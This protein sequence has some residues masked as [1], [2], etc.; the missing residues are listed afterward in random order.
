MS[1]R[2]MKYTCRVISGYGCLKAL[3]QVAVNFKAVV[4]RVRHCHVAIR[5]KGQALR[6]VK[7]ISWSVD[8]GQERPWAVKHLQHRKTRQVSIFSTVL[9][10]LQVFGVNVF[11]LKVN[12]D[13][14]VSPI[15]N[16]NISIGIDSHACW[17]VELAVSL[18]M[19]AKF[20]EELPISIV[21]L[22]A[23]LNTHTQKK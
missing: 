3:L 4:P 7:W 1:L 18:T 21:Y 16:N 11:F 13:P 22:S 12:L 19:G 9:Y 5:C 17:C 10:P 23:G 2:P 15:S 14:T 20:K 8:V 6:A